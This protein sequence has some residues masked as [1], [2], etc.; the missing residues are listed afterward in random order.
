VDILQIKDKLRSEPDLLVSL[1]EKLGYHSFT[2]RNKEIRCAVPD[3]DNNTSV[4]IKLDDNLTSV[5]FSRSSNDWDIIGLIRYAKKCSFNKAI[6]WLC[7]E[8]NVEY[9]EIQTNETY[10]ILRQFNKKTE[11]K[12]A[13]HE[14]LDEEILNKYQ[15]I[16]IEEWKKEGIN[17]ETQRKYQVMFD[18]VSNRIIFPIRD[19]NNNLINIKGRTCYNNYKE[20]GIAK[21]Q[22]YYPLGSNDILFGLNFNMFH[23]QQKN[24]VIIFEAEKS[25]MKCDSLGIYNSVAVSTHSIN[26]YQLK[27]IISLRCNVVI[28]FDKD[29]SYK[30][31]KKEAQKLNKYTNV[32]VIYDKDGLLGE[33]DAPIDKGLGVWLELYDKKIRM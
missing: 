22:Y 23:I 26:P 2:K 16:P 5:I 24:E 15:N 11:I 30:D 13:V 21:Y 19:E 9:T 29:V 18:D 32:Y 31:L 25:V 1:L 14:I 27:K 28:A 8:L 6:D 3:G 20:L 17:I 4:C 7:K 10:K 12:P 33:K